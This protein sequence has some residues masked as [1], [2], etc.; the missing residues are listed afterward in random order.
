M[1][2]SLSLSLGSPIAMQA[3][4]EMPI[5]FRDDASN[6]YQARVISAALY[7]IELNYIEW[8]RLLELGCWIIGRSK[9]EPPIV[10]ENSGK[11]RVAKLCYE[12]NYATETTW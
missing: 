8:L 7:D 3:K 11:D 2:R 9:N 5:R 4:N 12:L 6:H 10:V 1:P